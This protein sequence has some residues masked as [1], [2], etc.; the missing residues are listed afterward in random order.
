MKE[1]LSKKKMIDFAAI[2]V[3]VFLFTKM[4]L[5]ICYGVESV[6]ET[7][8]DAFFYRGVFYMLAAVFLAMQTD[9][10]GLYG[11]CVKIGKLFKKN[12]AKDKKTIAEYIGIF[13]IPQIV[14]LIVISVIGILYFKKNMFESEI[15]MDF[16]MQWHAKAL[17]AFLV[18]DVL[19]RRRHVKVK[20][21]N[22]VNCALFLLVIVFT[23]GISSSK[24]YSM[25]LLCPALCIYVCDITPVKWKKLVET[26][27]AG[28]IL[29]VMWLMFKSLKDV[30]YTGSRYK[31]VFLNVSTIGLFCGAGF[32]C[33]FYFFMKAKLADYKNK[34]LLVLSI[35]SMAATAAFVY[36]NGLRTAELG[37][38]AVVFVTL[39]YV[40][41]AQNMKVKPWQK[42]LI[43]C[44]IVV[45][46]L[47][48]GLLAL[49]V[50]YSFDY[51]T[52]EAAI[53]NQVLCKK[54]FYW[55]NRAGTMFIA[56]SRVFEDGTVLAAIDRFSSGRLG[57]WKNY[58]DTANLWGHQSVTLEVGNKFFVHPH[59]NFVAW[60]IMY[61]IPGGAVCII[62][63]VKMTAD[64]FIR[65]N[66]EKERL[67]LPF[68]WL[69]FSFIAL[70][71]E[72]IPW[73]Y[74]IL[75]I[76]LFLQYPFITSR[77]DQM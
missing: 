12:E 7:I 41:N 53:P 14:F 67:L 45:V 34:L 1:K 65:V 66:K 49:R 39:F 5:N 18:I 10:D 51:E 61:G 30:P 28:F 21:L 42:I 46:F 44:G 31:G 25:Y 33:S 17:G 63:F 20:N 19:A 22:P 2:F 60:I 64:S 27:A 6:Y 55:R 36:I 13:R 59:N 32:V 37:V 62:W 54:I 16:L 68:L 74:H 4:S 52:L 71:M 56:N 24:A 76:A 38:I 29:A 35:L 23:I 47:G 72:T 57:I 43:A 75:L 73:S 11:L 40:S 26:L 58:L 48:L 8:R 3:Y 70:F 77:R 69:V 50:L 15:F 9:D